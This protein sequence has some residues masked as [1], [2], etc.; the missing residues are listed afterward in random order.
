MSK[1]LRFSLLLL[2]VLITAGCPQG[3]GP[4]AI[5]AGTPSV[6]CADLN[7]DDLV[8]FRDLAILKNKFLTTDEV[9]DIY[10]DGIV[11]FR[12]L[13]IL[14][15]QFF[16]PASSSLCQTSD[17]VVKA[18]TPTELRVGDTVY[19]QG[20]GFNSTVEAKLED[21]TNPLAQ[22]PPVDKASSFLLSQNTVMFR[23]PHFQTGST[24]E[25]HR[26][27]LVISQDDGAG[28]KPAKLE[29]PPEHPVSV[30]A[31]LFL[32]SADTEP[33]HVIV[34]FQF[35]SWG[36]D[37]IRAIDGETPDSGT[38]LY[39]EPP[40]NYFGWDDSWTSGISWADF[41]ETWD[42]A[43]RDWA[44]ICGRVWA[45]GISVSVGGLTE[46]VQRVTMSWP[47]FAI[48]DVYDPN[49]MDGMAG[50]HMPWFSSYDPSPNTQ[51]LVGGPSMAPCQTNVGT[52]CQL[53]VG[54]QPGVVL[55][56]HVLKI[57]EGG[58]EVNPLI[59]YRA[60]MFDVPGRGKMYIISSNP[61]PPGISRPDLPIGT[62]LPIPIPIGGAVYATDPFHPPTPNLLAHELVHYFGFLDL[63]EPLPGHVNVS[64]P[65]DLDGERG[66]SMG[67]PSQPFT[68]AAADCRH[69]VNQIQ[70]GF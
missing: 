45:P 22:F 54:V 43:S 31:D 48:P 13:A 8:N 3:S 64:D 41:L 35:I 46:A 20:H 65:F 37:L 67:T 12:D 66:Y 59:A 27:R 53:F 68:S 50:G 4:T 61:G 62:K 28:R 38:L 36:I 1:T 11:N 16:K 21:P 26:Y 56:H 18:V 60:K 14:K 10:R 52:N 6:G 23:I 2:L 7:R 17:A 19:V 15:N 40:Y 39:Q 55:M 9:A 47:P 58:A 42:Q 5:A 70:G 49:I 25:R 30:A 29:K 34:R 33:A 32:R 63:E 57:T 69:I 24:G 44:T 51:H